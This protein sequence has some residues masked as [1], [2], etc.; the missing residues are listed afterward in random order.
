[1][2]KKILAAARSD[3]HRALQLRVWSVRDCIPSNSDKDNR[4]SVGIGLALAL[5]V[6]VTSD[7][8]RLRG[9]AAGTELERRVRVFL[10]DTFPRLGHLRPGVW[11]VRAGSAI[12][13]FE[14]YS[15]LE[16]LRQARAKNVAL[17]SVLQSDY[18]IKP[19]IIITRE[20]E[21]DERIN[22]NETF[23]VP[24]LARFTPL[25]RENTE[26]E[27][28]HASVSC[29]WTIRSDR[30]QNSRAEALNLLRNRKGRAPHIAVVTAEPLPS[31]LASI[32]IGTGDI[33]CTYHVALHELQDVVSAGHWPN[34]HDKLSIMVEG[35]RLRDISDLPL[36]LAI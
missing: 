13:G 30:T 7:L 24:E 19:D 25:R 28:L 6:G 20:P 31:R 36:D 33:D 3:F 17:K 1:M 32:A 16:E 2:T 18:T 4:A 12:S 35:K 11:H 34:A 27:L 23:V 10:Q 21:P 9:S 8:E 29:K 14:Q 26:L 22:Q 15:H 5:A